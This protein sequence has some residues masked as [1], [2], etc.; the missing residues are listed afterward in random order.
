[1]SH[2]SLVQ[3]LYDP[4]F[5]PDK[6]N[7]AEFVEIVEG[8]A[9][10]EVA[11]TIGGSPLVKLLT[12]GDV[13][14][15]LTWEEAVAIDDEITAVQTAIKLTRARIGGML[16]QVDLVG[17]GGAGGGQEITFTLDISKRHRLKRAIKKSFGVKT[18]TITYSMY[19]AAVEA[20]RQLEKDETKD[21]VNMK[22][23]K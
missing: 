9:A 1:M 23:K 14:K 19:K 18:D 20:K 4:T 8:K 12:S 11:R 3:Q 2:K 5:M 10:S 22:W 17:L 15:P 7:L 21:Y 16:S 6:L 13:P